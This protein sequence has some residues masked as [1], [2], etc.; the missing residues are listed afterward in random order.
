MGLHITFSS[1]SSSLLLN[2]QPS[3]DLEPALNQDL[4]ILNLIVSLKTLFPNEVT[5]TASE[6][7]ESICQCRRWGFDPWVGKILWR[8]KW[9]PT[10]SCL[11]GKSHRHR[12]LACCNSWGHKES[13]MTWQFNNSNNNNKFNQL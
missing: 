5:F 8:R 3:L 9:Q 13:D 11:S 12:S 4:E 1:L 7:K 2:G 10:P 6:E